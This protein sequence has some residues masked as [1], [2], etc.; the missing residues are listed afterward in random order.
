MNKMKHLSVGTVSFDYPPVYRKKESYTGGPPDT[1]KMFLN[2]M[3][4]ERLIRLVDPL[5]ELKSR[6]EGA[7][8]IST[9][10]ELETVHEAFRKAGIDCLLIE[11]KN[12]TRV[13]LV[14]RLIRELD[15]PTGLV[16]VTTG[17]KSG[18][19]AA[20]AVSASL[21]ETRNSRNIDLTER[22]LDTDTGRIRVWLKGIAGLQ[23]LKHSRLL[24]FGGSYGAE[25]PFTRGDAA[26]LESRFIRE[27]LTEQEMVIIEK[28]RA[29]TAGDPARI[30][31][32]RKWLDKYG[33]NIRHDDAMVTDESL[34]FQTAMY[35]AVRDRLSE[36]TDENITG[37]SIKCHFEVSTTC[38]GCT[39]CMIPAFLPFGIDAEGEQQVVPVACEG[40]TLGLLGLVLLHSLK[41]EIPPL[42]GDIAAYKESHLL[43]RN[44]GA[45]SVYWAGRSVDPS[46]SLPRT[47]L[48]PN[49]HGKS[50]AAV[51]YETPACD[52]VTTARLFRFKDEY[53]L[54]YG[55][56]GILPETRDTAYTD[57]WPHTRLK[58]DSSPSLLYRTAP[59]N[60][61]SLTEGDVTRE[62]EVFCRYS[63]IK[64]V[65]CNSDES[66][67]TFLEIIQGEYDA[68]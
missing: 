9:A 23:R 63:G 42:F 19:T 35:L 54:Y 61:T 59:C 24:S 16:A 60:H 29:L 36:L 68:I 26:V 49:I 62:L 12:W 11:L 30:S 43:L 40:D 33:V 56:A 10:A 44:C 41:P 65:R 18:I 6:R 64:R 52:T 3:T 51:H 46:V 8:G 22:F 45:S 38:T 20:T 28:A 32:F 15:V 53:Y 58:Y 1:F 21:G 13:S 5:R 34:A 17:G 4:E 50:G 14:T 7:F 67:N 37:V 66:L 55:L 39:M 47:E 48:L 25:I 31:R 27:I 2:T 57:P